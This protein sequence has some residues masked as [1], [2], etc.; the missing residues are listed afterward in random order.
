M[1]TLADVPNVVKIELVYTIGQDANV[2]SRFYMAYT[3]S[4][5]TPA[6]L[7][8]LAQSVANSWETALGAHL[9]QAFY[10]N[11]VNVYDLASG[12]ETYGTWTGEKIGNSVGAALTAE[13]ACVVNFHIVRRYRGGHPRIYLPIGVVTDLQSPQ[14]WT[15]SFISSVESGW[16]TFIS[17]IVGFAGPPTV[18]GQVSVSY[19][20]SGQWVQHQPSGRYVYHPFPRTPPLVDPV[21]ST[22][23]RTIPGSQRRRMV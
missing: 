18:S 21:T 16:T 5:V 2:T 9:N 11:E 19:F 4:G 14:Q 17:D 23:V 15:S 6:G 1:T 7:A 13:T 10:L 3:G 22:S 8:A 12:G 20:E